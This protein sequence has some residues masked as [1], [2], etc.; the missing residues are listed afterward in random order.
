[1]ATSADPA[2]EESAAIQALADMLEKL[3]VRPGHFGQ[4]CFDVLRDIEVSSW[5]ALVS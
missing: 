1:M 5:S 4:Y 2:Q 3:H